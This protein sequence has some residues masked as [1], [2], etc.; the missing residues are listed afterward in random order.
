MKFL[1]NF[2]K[3]LRVRGPYESIHLQDERRLVIRSPNDESL[4][5]L[6]KIGDLAKSMAPL[7]SRMRIKSLTKDTSANLAHTCYGLADMS[8]FLLN[9]NHE[10]VALGCF[11]TDPLEKEFSILRQGC[12]GSYFITVQQALNKN[13]IRKTKLCLQQNPS[14]CFAPERASCGGHQCSKCLFTP[15]ESLCSLI[16][17]LPQLEYNLPV[18]IKLVLV[19]IAG[20][21]MRHTECED[22]TFCIYS[23]YGSYLKSLNRSGLKIPGDCA[24]LW[25]FFCYIVFHDLA[26]LTCRTS[27]CRVFLLI[28]EFY[29]FNISQ[30]QSRILCNIFFNNYSSL[31]S[32]RSARE[33]RQKILKLS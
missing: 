33:S 16:E 14:I 18:D 8:K 24:C 13:E 3:S 27:L 9:Q 2:G 7:T 26:D 30:S 17:N 15:N 25:S 21:V 28:S 12:G 22:D 5:L 11:T 19:Y 23:K 32:P 29:E 20:Y 6:L 10:Y 1:L 4:K 31:Y